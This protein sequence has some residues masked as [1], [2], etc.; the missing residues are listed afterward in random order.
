MIRLFAALLLVLSLP[1]AANPDD[2]CI[3]EA[4]LMSDVGR[5][6]DAGERMQDLIVANYSRFHDADDYERYLRKV[7]LAYGNPELSAEDMTDAI[8]GACLND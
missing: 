8:Y 6:R 5:A 4:R 3:V 1:A 2:P 7:A